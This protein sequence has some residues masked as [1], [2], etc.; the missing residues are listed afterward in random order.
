MMVCDTGH[1]SA[2]SAVQHVI[3]CSLWVLNI[4]SIADSNQQQQLPHCSELC[5]ACLN[6][7]SPCAAVPEYLEYN[8]HYDCYMIAEEKR[9]AM[10]MFNVGDTS[11]VVE[12][13]SIPCCANSLG[14]T[15]VMFC[16]VMSQVQYAHAVGHNIAPQQLFAPQPVFAWM[17]KHY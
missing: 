8:P 13:G 1:S 7:G 11:H 15:Y 10:L 5:C 3:Q 14:C 9:G 17:R 4:L 2:A 6:L 12:S 16:H